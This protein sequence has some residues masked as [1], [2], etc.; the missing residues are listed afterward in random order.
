M[1]PRLAADDR[2]KEIVGSVRKIIAE[3][4]LDG[5]KS[6]E[7]ARAA[8]VSEGLLFKYF[9]NKE[10]LHAAI[11]SSMC[12][13]PHLPD[14]PPS[15]DALI[16]HLRWHLHWLLVKP[17]PEEGVDLGRMLLRSIA[18][19]GEFARD[20]YAKASSPQVGWIEKCLAAA[21]KAGE[22]E[23]PAGKTNVRAWLVVLL[24]GQ[25]AAIAMAKAVDFGVSRETLVE[26]TLL[27]SLRGLGF[28]DEVLRRSRRGKK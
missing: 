25:V 19:D 17:G 22:L 20:F 5:V 15:S 27:F 7:L 10:A 1:A 3:K 26:E 9:P 18:G 4:G 28:K 8:G 11:Q 16:D 14:V 23:R 6:C 12:M 2:R 21:E 24:R 13:D